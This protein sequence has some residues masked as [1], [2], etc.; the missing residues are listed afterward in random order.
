M[1]AMLWEAK[2]A[3]ENRKWFLKHINDNHSAKLDSINW[4]LISETDRQTL[5]EREKEGETKEGDR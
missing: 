3:K 1:Q 4:Y 5:R 2:R